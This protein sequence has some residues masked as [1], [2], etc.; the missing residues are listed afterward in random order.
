MADPSLEVVKTV[1]VREA[2]SRV[3][4]STAAAFWKNREI[5]KVE[6]MNSSIQFSVC[7]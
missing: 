6:L 4:C 3:V 2:L 7:V 1:V 5:N